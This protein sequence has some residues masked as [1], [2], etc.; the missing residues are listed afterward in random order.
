MKNP[1]LDSP[2]H[3]ATSSSGMPR[4]SFLIGAGETAPRPIDP[5]HYFLAIGGDGRHL[6]RILRAQ[7][8]PRQSHYS[9]V[10]AELGH[11]VMKGVLRREDAI[12]SHVAF[13]RAGGFDGN[14]DGLPL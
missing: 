3:R 14:L 7:L 12:I 1:S 2:G 13:S 9:R 11:S 10:R 5:Y 6:F 4:R 8:A